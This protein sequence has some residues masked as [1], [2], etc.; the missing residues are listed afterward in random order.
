MPRFFDFV[1]IWT[2]WLL[3]KK[4]LYLKNN[5]EYFLSGKL[6]LVKRGEGEGYIFPFRAVFLS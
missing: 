2:K 6:K 1:Y 4:F 5:Q 3:L